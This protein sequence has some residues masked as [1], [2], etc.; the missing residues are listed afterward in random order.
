V[1]R[2]PGVEGRK[3]RHSTSHQK[4]D[5]Q[6]KDER[7]VVGVSVSMKTGYPLTSKAPVPS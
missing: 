4:S 7:H 6:K 3:R 1:T 5:E 2:E